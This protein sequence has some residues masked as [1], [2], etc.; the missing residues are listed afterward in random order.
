L[1]PKCGEVYLVSF[2][3]ALGAEIHNTR[4]ALILQNDIGNLHSPVTIVAAIT[5]NVRR[6]GPTRAVFAHARAA[7]SC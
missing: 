2:D 1:T 6:Q 5:S 3:P 4:P 7:T